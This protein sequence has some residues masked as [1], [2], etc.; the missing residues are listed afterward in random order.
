MSYRRKETTPEWVN[1]QHKTMIR[2]VNS[3]L[4]I[5][6]SNLSLELKDGLV[7]IALI[8]KIV[9]EVGLEKTN[10]K[11]YL[12]KPLYMTPKFDI[13][14]M[15][16]INDFLEF[17]RIVLKINVLSISGDNILE[18]NLKL[19]LG[20][21]WSIFIF[22]TTNSM[23]ILN[24][25][26]SIIE[27]KNYLLKWVNQVYKM[28]PINNFNRDWSIEVNNPECIFESI[29]KHYLPHDVIDINFNDTKL[30]KMKSIL[31]FGEDLGIPKLA[32]LDDFKTL[33]P[34]EKCILFYLI[35]W[36]KFFELNKFEKFE[37]T[38]I[39]YDK[40]ILKINDTMRSKY[41]Y[42]TKA[43]RF[44][45]K[46]NMINN[47]FIILID[48]KDKN[49][50]T[51][52]EILNEWGSKF[53]E[54][55]ANDYSSHEISQFNEVNE[56][57][58]S[59][60]QTLINELQQLDDLNNKQVSEL[61]YKDLS[62]IEFIYKQTIQGLSKVHPNIKFCPPKSLMFDNLLVKFKTIISHQ[63]NYLQNYNE[64]LS[65]LLNDTNL[66][67]INF[68]LEL[69]EKRIRKEHTDDINKILDDFLIIIKSIHKINSYSSSFKFTKSPE[70]LK[71]LN[72]G[73][74]DSK[75]DSQCQE[76]NNDYS[77]YTRLKSDLLVYQEDAL[78][79]TE[80]IETLQSLTKELSLKEIKL[81][82]SYFPTRLIQLNSS[83]SDFSLV[84]EDDEQDSFDVDNSQL[85]F[86]GNRRKLSCQLNGNTDK[87]YDINEFFQK[88]E[89]GIL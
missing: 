40:L 3:K 87:V 38:E 6:L 84:L 2:W 59:D 45:N 64:F 5:Q 83:D 46:L 78:N 16:N 12:L 71:L 11:L 15:E 34:D 85:I 32:D 58:K 4:D 72:S 61:I 1:Q 13:Q 57:V 26:N 81:F 69:I 39:I 9:S 75:N 14:K 80:F 77:N 88:F 65:H 41:E 48:N 29:L 70:Q 22:S 67:K 49:T 86:E 24:D 37:P 44:S 56:Y 82:I 36:Y 19:I 60:L 47:K 20:L 28:N 33:V 8:N 62:E 27:I 10:L 7:L 52:N 21:I 74:F 68:Y 66:S 51:L 17:I 54:T 50:A 76:D 53:M 23:G 35:E 73:T 31:K 63:D 55:D 30:Q 79:E 89:L 43:L 25:N 18:G 42:E